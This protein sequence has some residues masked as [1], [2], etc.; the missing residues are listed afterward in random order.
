M[1][2]TIIGITFIAIGTAICLRIITLASE[3]F[4][5]VDVWRGTKLWFAIFGAMDLSN[6]Q[7][8]FLGA[9][10]VLGVI[11]FF[12][13]LLILIVEYFNLPNKVKK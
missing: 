7:S 13:G 8:L 3:L 10:F 2:K 1:K 4:P 6:E 12:L 11:L 5:T 9:P